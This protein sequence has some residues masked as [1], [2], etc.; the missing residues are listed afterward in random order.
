MKNELP[1]QKIFFG[2]RMEFGYL[3]TK[4]LSP[5]GMPLWWH[6]GTSYGLFDE[7]KIINNFI[8]AKFDVL[9]FPKVEKFRIPDEILY[10]IADHY[11]LD[12]KYQYIDVY[13]KINP[14]SAL[15]YYDKG[16]AYAKLGRYKSAIECYNQAIH[17]DSDYTDAHYIRG[18]LYFELGQ[19][20]KAI[21]DF[22]NTIRIQPDYINAYYHRG[23]AYSK[24]RQ[25]RQAIEDFSNAIRLKPDHADAYNNR[26]AVFLNLGNHVLG[27]PDARRACELG[28]CKVFKIAKSNGICH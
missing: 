9:I 4:S 14:N 21:Q 1:N 8:K 22:N 15:A 20:Q 27:C 16:N 18:I 2:P 23:I 12:A 10:F 24:M 11:W 25:E 28:N 5:Y 7:K 6:P 13:K 3:Y 26:S 17:I 19:Y